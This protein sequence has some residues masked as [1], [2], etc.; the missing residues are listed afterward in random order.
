MKAICILSL[1]SLVL[2]QRSG[3]W[4][5]DTFASNDIRIDRARSTAEAKF[6]AETNAKEEEFII[7]PFAVYKQL[8]NGLNYKIFFAA[9]NIKTNT[10]ELF[11]YIVY[12]GAF[13]APT[14]QVF[15]YQVIGTK[16]LDY[17]DKLKITN[18]K[19]GKINDAVALYY[20]PTSNKMSYI[21]TIQVN[22]NVLYTMS[23]YVVKVQTESQQ[24]PQTLIVMEQDDNTFEVVADIRNFNQ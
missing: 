12:T 17:D 24:K 3:G 5:Q 8:V 15:D 19:F 14:N 21:E 23:I 1:I 6:F 2:S 22:E 20:S 9:Q 11:D 7:Y 13:G 16:K 4:I 18:K 10:I